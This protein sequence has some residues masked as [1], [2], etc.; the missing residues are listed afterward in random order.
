MQSM[1]LTTER[2]RVE[3]G[4]V[5]PCFSGCCK[6]GRTVWS[7]EAN[8]KYDMAKRTTGGG[9]GDSVELQGIGLGH[10]LPAELQQAPALHYSTPTYVGYWRMV[11]DARLNTEDRVCTLNV[12]ILSRSRSGKGRKTKLTIVRPY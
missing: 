11:G 3:E 1:Q 7:A 12:R 5:R 2:P 9:Y 8:E 6:S 10:A 4:L